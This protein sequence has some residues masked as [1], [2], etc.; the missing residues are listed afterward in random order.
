MDAFA[1]LRVSGK[2][3][4]DGDGFARQEQAI[5]RYATAHGI[6]ITRVFREEG[7][8]WHKGHGRPTCS[9]GIDGSNPGR[10]RDG[11]Y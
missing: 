3:Q 6:T 11:H 10:G 9:S 1:Y 7:G 8:E 4:I 2:S 5:R